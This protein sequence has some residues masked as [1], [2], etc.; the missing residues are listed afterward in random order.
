VAEFRVNVTADTQD[1][2]R[3]LRSVDKTASEATKA[4]SIKIDAS[5]F[6]N[7][8]KRFKDINADIKAAGN[9]IQ[10]FYRFSKNVPGIGERVRE[11]EGLAKS[12]ANL[13]RI[14]PESAA[15]LRENAKAGSILANSFETAG[16]AAGRLINSLAKA[17]FALFAIK[18]AVGVLRGAFNG[19]F[20]ETIGRE[21]KLR[22]TILKTQTTL[23]STNKVFRNGTEITDPYE[24]IVSLTGEVAKRI[25]S[26]RERSIALAGVTS[27][28]VIEVFGIVSTQIG[29]IG[30]G[31]KDAEDLAI[32]FAAALGTFGIPLYQARQEIGSI[33][34]GDI[35][36]DSY[37]A[38]A[39]GITNQ[40]IARAK[41]Q[42]GGVIKFLEERL[43]ASVAGQR[44]A[45]QG[46]AGVVSNIRDLSELVS[47]RFGAGLLD[48]L[49]G[50]LS[51]TFEFLFRIR[52]QIFAIAEASGRGLGSLL[53]TNLTIIGGGSA[54]FEQMGAGAE[55]F[56]TQL[57]EGVKRAFASLQADASSFVAPLRNLLEEVSKS[58]AVL[59]QGLA[60]LAQGFVSIQVENFKALVQIFS[61]LSEAVTAFTAGLSQVLRVYG[62]L[63]QVP[64]VQYLSQ[65]STQFQLLEKLGVMSAV[66]LGFAAVGLITAWTPI[67]TFFQGLVARVAALIGGLVIAVGAAFTRIGAIVAA[68]AGTLTATYPAVEAL[69]QQLM[70]LSASLTT[71]GVAADKAG[72][73][74]SRFG[75]A[76]TAAA[77]VVGSAILSF[78]KFN[79][80]LLGVQLA[81]T[82]LIDI[83]GRWQR[84]KDKQ[85]SDKRAEESLK[86][87]ATKYKNIGDNADAATRAAKD[88]HE[89]VVNARYQAAI[90]EVETLSKKLAELEDDMAKPPKWALDGFFQNWALN[91]IPEVQRELEKAIKERDKWAKSTDKSNNPQDNIRLEANNRTNLEKEITELRR[92]QESQIF[93]LRQSLAQKEVD[94]FRTAGEFRIFQMEQANKKLIEGEEGASAVALEA[95]NNYLS[96]RERGELDI[97]ASKKQLVI[98]AANLERQISDYRLENEKKIAEIRKRAGEYEKNMAD[99]RRQAAGQIA[100]GTG[101]GA[102]TFGST[103][104]VSNA[105]GWVHGHFQTNTG[106]LNDLIGDVI[107]VLKGLLDQ[108]IPVELS[109]G[110][111]VATGKDDGYYR[112]ILSD[113]AKQHGHSGDGRSLDLFVPEGTKVPVPLTNVTGNT[114]RGGI[115]GG[116]PGSGKSWLGHLE[117]GSKAGGAAPIAPPT[118]PDFSTVAAPAVEKYA[119]AVRSLGSAM[120]RLR[121]LQ[122]ALTDAKTA[123]A[124]EEIAKA[125]FKPVTLEQYQDQLYEVQLTYD[126]IVATSAEAFDPERAQIAIEQ[127][128]KVAA[129]N[130]ELAQIIAGIAARENIDQAKKKALIDQ[131]TAQH[132]L[133]V[134]SL[135]QEEAQRL[136]IQTVQAAT[137]AIQDIKNQTNEIYKQIEADKLRSRLEAEGVAPERIQAE[138]SK[139]AIRRQLEKLQTQLN[140]QLTTELNLR[141]EIA[142]KLP[143]ATDAERKEL[144]RQL[145]AALAE[146]ARLKKLLEDLPKTESE[147]FTALDTQAKPVSPTDKIEGRIGQLKKEMAELTNI[148]NIAIKVADGIGAAF[149]QAFQGLITGS[150]TARE[151]LGSFFKSVGQMF[152]EMATEIIAK[153]MVM[154]VL[155]TILKALGAAGGGGFK[156][157]DN[158]GATNF[159][160]NP[161]A[162]TGGTP[163]SF[164]ANANGNAFGQNGIVPYA[165]GGV[166]NRPTM[167]KFAD[168]G[169]MQNGVMGE[170]GPEAIM[171]LKRGADGKLG[172]VAQM[173]GA[174][175][176]YRRPPGAAAAVAEGAAATEG[177][178]SA[179][180]GGPIDVRYTVERIN[181][182]DYVTANQFQAGLQQAASQ[183]AQRG[184]Q[185]A[186]RR[187]Q[188]SRSTRSRLGMA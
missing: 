44:I 116:L 188:Q 6:E 126:A 77:R 70:G 167:F 21:V 182:V 96:I 11:F 145:D 75:G 128:T 184:E 13:A 46:F 143:Q 81:V 125:A 58:I 97:E 112:R 114:G 89:A 169:A 45:A 153:Q 144:Q 41:S 166:V 57:T 69:K 124:F 104:N 106:T 105:P 64:F 110:T 170:A 71:A 50:G 8:S 142:K 42:A 139:L 122:A 66:K 101:G 120:E 135:R 1:A 38:K 37:L 98:E 103:G 80:I 24:K 9:N 147:A 121:A 31:L 176:R 173:T 118:A 39:L 72:V 35:T 90:S 133:Y 23:A 179:A 27:N 138:L 47:Q 32:N 146:I 148:G 175:S 26:I 140:D 172:V 150:M 28:E 159:G 15:A 163:W 67:V 88:F 82:G 14:A 33:L 74:V 129:S 162:M 107:P 43:A 56:A 86:L 111:R 85:V 22:E 30:G 174:M 84:A 180:V 158:A 25:D 55:G 63:L 36:M 130:R 132:R 61:N 165:K 155:Q 161:G 152:I 131:V 19:F 108:G 168:G 59:S 53:G 20:N 115:T 54:L 186:L 91:R 65:I 83:F 185:A 171:P 99:Y 119:A 79:L 29:Q 187:L 178:A 87:L 51:S 60:R 134:D 149:G 151:A 156:P 73:S 93:Q 92:Q 123:A 137:Q 10:T 7:I 136:R 177:G 48:P 183:G 52:E 95:L 113:A 18:E 62:Q 94:I 4:R 102:A 157:L 109:N 68:F 141:D 117:P 16:G 34:R 17:G 78:I 164:A 12:A 160:F 76:T 154:I 40:D 127:T 181:S 5:G 2:E 3:K 49:L 100:A